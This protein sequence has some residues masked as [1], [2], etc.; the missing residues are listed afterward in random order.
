[1]GGTERHECYE[2]L[3]VGYLDISRRGERSLDQPAAFKV[4]TPVMVQPSTGMSLGCYESFVDELSM[5]P[6]ASGSPESTCPPAQVTLAVAYSFPQEISICQPTG[7]LDGQP[8]VV[9]HLPSGSRN[10]DPHWQLGEVD[11]RHS[12]KV[13]E[14][15]QLVSSRVEAVTEVHSALDW[16]A[17]SA[18][19]V[20]VETLAPA[21][22]P[23]DT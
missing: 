4:G 17:V 11:T 5:P 1:M 14:D 3:G 22:D 12:M 18:K 21:S 16:H 20:Q 19:P 23:Q 8:P 9:Q 6:S 13:S 2:Q 7:S 15:T 10:E